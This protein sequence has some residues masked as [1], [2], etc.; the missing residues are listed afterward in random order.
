MPDSPDR[1]KYWGEAQ[2]ALL[3]DFDILPLF[4]DVITEFARKG[5]TFKLMAPFVIDFSTIRATE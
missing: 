2:E 1:C 3:K 5:I 4:A